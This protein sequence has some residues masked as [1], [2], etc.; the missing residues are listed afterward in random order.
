MSKKRY[1]QSEALLARAVRS[2]PLGSQTFSKSMVQYPLGVSPYFIEKG[3]GSRVWDVDGH[4][5]VDFVSGLLCV[6]LGYADAEVN[7]AITE[8]LSRG[9]S[10]SLP[11]RLEISVAEL[12]IELVPCA[13]MVRFGKNGTDATSAAV[14]LARAHTGREHVL[15]CGYHGWQDWFIGS[16]SRGLGVPDA[17]KQLT[18][19][20]KYNDIEGLQH[21]FRQFPQDIAAVI[22]EPMNVA[23]PQADFLSAVKT[24]T[25]EHG[26][27]LIFDEMVTACRFHIGGAQALFAV[28]PDLATLG[29]G[30][31]NGLPLSAVVGRRDIMMGMEE[32][33]FSGTFGGETLSLAAAKVVLERV[34]AGHVVA[35]LAERGG[36]VLE[37][38]A[39]LLQQHQA[40]AYF[41]LSGH[42]AWSFLSCV[43][44]GGYTAWE[45]KTLLLQEMLKRGILMIGSHNI[46]CAHTEQDVACLLAAYDQVLPLISE[47]IR[48]Q[49]LHSA[50]QAKPL[51]PVFVLRD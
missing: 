43:D 40:E 44:A 33:F 19:T 50:L 49:S 7:Q 26:A 23:W 2:I 14:R 21:W 34:K 29:K 9:I 18:H 3:L 45:I 30:M 1:A 36:Q 20:F 39:H 41:N 22:M 15:V 35:P 17:V 51:K 42:P 5:Y 4:E 31:G 48:S 8:Q 46:S 37:G 25:H 10:F 6:L 24:C 11:H 27:L 16:T 12:L 47:A 38:V 32:I 28:T 13:E